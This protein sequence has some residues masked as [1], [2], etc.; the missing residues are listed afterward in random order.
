MALPPAVLPP[1]AL[2]QLG[3]IFDAALV[4]FA[5]H[6][7]LAAAIAPLAAHVQLAAAI[8]P[9]A[10]QSQLAAMQVQMQAQ[11]AAVQAQMQAQL[12]AVQAPLAQMQ[13][14]FLPLNVPTIEAAATMTV[15]SI[16]FSRM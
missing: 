14:L 2:T 8:A 4:G 12:A 7:Q 11:L 16:G 6:A 9:L 10:T 5:T 3:A 13:A 1:A 15:Q